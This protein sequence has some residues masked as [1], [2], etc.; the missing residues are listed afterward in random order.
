MF[1]GEHLAG[2]ADSGL[3]LVEDEEDAVLVAELAEAGEEAGR[4]DDVA[5]F[6]LDGLDEDGGEFIGGQGGF[7]EGADAVEVSVD[8]VLDLGDHGGE[9]SAVD[10]LRGAQGHGAVG[11]AVEGFAG[12]T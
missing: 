8:G 1:L 12:T 9:A 3:D 10:W 4:G 5:A 2:S 11:S 6:A 7:E